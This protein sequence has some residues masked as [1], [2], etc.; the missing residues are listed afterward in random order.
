M[1]AE[2]KASRVAAKV[3]ELLRHR[4]GTQAEAC[5]R[6]GVNKNYWKQCSERG[7]IDMRAF[8][9]A[10]EVLS[11]HPQLFFEA[12]FPATLRELAGGAIDGS[13]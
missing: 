8:L 3:Y 13:D 2:E 5:R 7:S 4:R 1:D 11:M 6:A 12:Y 10:L 9:V